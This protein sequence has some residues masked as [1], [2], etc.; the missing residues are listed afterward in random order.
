MDTSTSEIE[1]SSQRRWASLG[2]KT[3]KCCTAWGRLDGRGTASLWQCFSSS[4]I[5]CSL[6]TR[7]LYWLLSWWP[8]CIFPLHSLWRGT[9]VWHHRLQSVEN[10]LLFR[11]IAGIM[12]SV[13]WSVLRCTA[14]I[15]HFRAECWCSLWSTEGYKRQPWKNQE[16]FNFLYVVLVCLIVFFVWLWWREM[17]TMT[18]KLYTT[19]VSLSAATN[20]GYAHFSKTKIYW[21]FIF[22]YAATSNLVFSFTFKMYFLLTVS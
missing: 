1:R 8:F 17:E 4:D 3:R 11:V 2:Q 10:P 12:D 5:I 13:P 18:Y 9:S 20:V 21:N 16:Q 22:L 15:T 14:A 7:E 6:I 19:S